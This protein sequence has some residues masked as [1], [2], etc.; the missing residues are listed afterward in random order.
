M[1]LIRQ[2]LKHLCLLLALAAGTALADTPVLDIYLARHGQTD[3]NL[4][5][6]LQGGTDNPLNDT[7]R[8]QAKQLGDKLAGVPIK[9]V[10]SSGL[11]RARETAVLALP[12][13]KATPLPALSERSFGK[14]E[15]MY[16]DG[17]DAAMSAEFKA[18]GSQPDDGLDGGE[19]LNSQA[20]RVAQAIDQIRKAHA[21]G[22]V[23]VVSHGG[24]TPLILGHLLKLPVPEAVARIKQSN[25]E[26][27]LVRLIGQQPPKIF[28]LITG[29]TLEQL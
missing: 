3:W 14:F 9:A 20:E 13:V 23:L 5:K 26:V 29:E 22:S 2:T 1:K 12:A 4:E 10:Y 6:R 24:V 25:D 21:K 27:Y 19:S 7:G 11:V 16:E 17:R 28:K 15:G 8:Q 18:R